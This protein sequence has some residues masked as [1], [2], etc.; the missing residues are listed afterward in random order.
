MDDVSSYGI[1][2]EKGVGRALAHAIENEKIDLLLLWASF[3]LV[4]GAKGLANVSLDPGAEEGRAGALRQPRRHGHDEL[5]LGGGGGGRVRRA[6]LDNR[7]V[8]AAHLPLVRHWSP[9]SRP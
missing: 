9:H 4:Q 2:T 5:L 3:K 6:Q 7:R 8:S 1:V